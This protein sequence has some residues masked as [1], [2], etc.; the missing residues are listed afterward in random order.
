T[1]VAGPPTVNPPPAADDRQ[2]ASINPWAKVCG[3]DQNTDEWLCLVSRELRSDFGVILA[4]AAIV[5]KPG[6]QHTRLLVSVPAA[7]RLEAG[8]DV[9]VDTA[10][11]LKAR[12]VLCVSWNCYAE[13]AIDA[14]F[15][16]ALKSGHTLQLTS[17]NQWG[18]PERFELMLA[19]FAE[20][21]D[22]DAMDDDEVA[23]RQ[24][25]IES[26]LG[27]LI[28]GKADRFVVEE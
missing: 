10:E 4:T 16:G 23:A 19:G 22:G 9:R 6:G 2:W 17:V 24:E 11:P 3:T 25:M 8:V 7:M 1:A 21:Y 13:L 12:Y 20:A 26:A 14:A 18:T 5:E 27:S 28:L 15:F